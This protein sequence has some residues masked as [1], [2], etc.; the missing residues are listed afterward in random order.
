MN[1]ICPGTVRTPVP[2]EMLRRRGGGDPEQGAALTARK[3]L[4]GRLGEPEEIA[5][6]ALFLA[7]PDSSFLTG[8]VIVADGGVT[9]R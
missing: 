1:C 5:S 3:Y 9:A 8:A 4:L 7:G 2:E 6:T